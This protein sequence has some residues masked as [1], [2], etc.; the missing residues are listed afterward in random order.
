MTLK[1]DSTFT[2]KAENPKYCDL[3]GTTWRVTGA[4]F[5]ASGRD[6]DNIL[7]TFA[8]PVSPLRLT[9]TWTATSGR[10]GWFTVAK[11]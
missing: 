6:C 11:K 9:G 7:V 10:G 4:N 2:G 1:A 3:M 5:T 8:A